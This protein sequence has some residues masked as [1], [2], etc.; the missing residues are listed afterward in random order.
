MTTREEMDL[1]AIEARH[2]EAIDRDTPTA[3]IASWSDVPALVAAV[4]S[5]DAALAAAYAALRVCA[6][7]CDVCADR[8]ATRRASCPVRIVVCDR[9]ECEAH[10]QRHL[11]WT[12]LPHADALRAAGGAR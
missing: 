11:A 10:Y 5:R 7:R 6:V 2:R 4:R 12:D 3:V 1:D 8:V 9:A